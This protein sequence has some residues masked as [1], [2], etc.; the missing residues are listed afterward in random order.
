LPRRP[1]ARSSEGRGPLIGYLLA[2]HK[3]KVIAIGVAACL[4]VIF[5]VLGIMLP[6]NR[7]PSH[8]TRPPVSSGPPAAGGQELGSSDLSAFE[9]TQLD[10]APA[11][12]PAFSP[13]LPAIPAR[14]RTQ[15]DLYA[16]ALFTA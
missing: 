7:G 8:A 10:A 12:A 2:A 4:V 15:A 5:A 16:R 11:V 14:Q 9:R 3:G 13:L 1:S 6:G